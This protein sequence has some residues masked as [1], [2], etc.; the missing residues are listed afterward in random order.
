MR[1]RRIA[2]RF[3]ARARHWGKPHVHCP[4]CGADETIPA[5]EAER[6][7]FTCNMPWF[8]LRGGAGGAGAAVQV[9]YGDRAY[10]VTERPVILDMPGKR[11]GQ[12]DGAFVYLPPVSP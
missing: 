7:C 6:I 12:V 1:P 4:G 9:R 3:V 5:D 8:W 10:T 11:T 2:R